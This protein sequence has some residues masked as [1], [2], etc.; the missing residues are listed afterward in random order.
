MSD[1]PPPFVD[2]KIKARLEQSKQR[3]TDTTHETEKAVISTIAFA[4]AA[5][6]W[7][8]A[9][10]RPTRIGAELYAEIPQQSHPDYAVDQ[11]VLAEIFAL[12]PEI[13][14]ITS[15]PQMLS[16]WPSIECTFKR[17]S[18]ATGK[19]TRL[20]LVS[21]VQRDHTREDEY[22]RDEQLLKLLGAKHME[23][24]NLTD[25]F[26][27]DENNQPIDDTPISDTPKPL[28]GRVHFEKDYFLVSGHIAKWL[29]LTDK[30]D[31]GRATREA[32]GGKTWPE[33]WSAS[34]PHTPEQIQTIADH[35]AR[36]ADE[37][38]SRHLSGQS[39]EMTLA[40]ARNT[41][42][43]TF[44]NYNVDANKENFKAA[45]GYDNALQYMSQP[46]ASVEGLKKAIANWCLA[47]NA[48]MQ[49]E[50]A[51]NAPTTNEKAPTGATTPETP[52]APNSTHDNAVYQASAQKLPPV[53]SK[54]S[55]GVKPV[56]QP[57]K[58]DESA[59]RAKYTKKLQ[60]GKE[61]LEVA[62]RV[63]L[64]R[65]DHPAGS[66]WGIETELLHAD[67]KG[68]VFKARIVNNGITVSTG[69]ARA[70]FEKSNNFGGRIFEKAETA[71]LGRALA[72]AGYGT[73]DVDE[74]E[75]PAHLADSPRSAA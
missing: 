53:Q 42:M 1:T 48:T 39:F 2:P 67:D 44:G 50:A 29:K 62:G 55:N 27:R 59:I 43:V 22:S 72:N 34:D 30:A 56:I 66:G 14:Y 10:F 74:T 51:K 75:E 35:I 26:P 7:T 57:I 65:I 37:Y 6:R 38:V 13:K 33:F 31:I 23:T 63:L 18:K 12:Y 3:L 19:G 49:N 9:L 54:S 28:L 25:F 15:H 60:G 41:A 61:Y 5:H 8:W 11:A 69:H 64:F 58:L 70:T 68:A 17:I 45:T 40:T 20:Q 21:F 24:D 71:A 52:P 4:G 36:M 47:H 46:G 73:D 16:L 32:L